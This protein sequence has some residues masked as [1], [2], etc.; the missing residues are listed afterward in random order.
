M[1]DKKELFKNMLQNMSGQGLFPPPATKHL[2]IEWLDY[3]PGKLIRHKVALK[4][5]FYNPGKVIFGGY[6][7]M[8]LDAAFGPFSFLE[9]QTYCASLDLNLSFIKSMSVEDGHAFV[10]ANLVSLSKSYVIMDGHVRKE[11]GTLVATATT[12]MAILDPSRR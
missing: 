1:I 11:D 3:E 10:Q 12:R 2:T 9:T 6:Y 4:E 5:E 7:G 8:F